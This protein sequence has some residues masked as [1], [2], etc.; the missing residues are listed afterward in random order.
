MPSSALEVK[1]GFGSL[2]F[3]E[4]A[5]R[6]G[7]NATVLRCGERGRPAFTAGGTRR[8]ESIAATAAAMVDT[9]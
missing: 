9:V 2:I 4:V 8:S 6:A 1:K 5:R 3:G 7:V